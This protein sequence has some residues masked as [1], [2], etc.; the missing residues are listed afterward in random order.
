[1][2]VGTIVGLLILLSIIPIASA[3]CVECPDLYSGWIFF[4]PKVHADLLR[5]VTIEPVEGYLPL[6]VTVTGEVFNS[7]NKSINCIIWIKDNG[8]VL[9]FE[10]TILWWLDTCDHIAPNESIPFSF[11]FTLV[12]EGI[13]NVT[14]MVGAGDLLYH[15][16]YDTYNATIKVLGTWILYD[17]NN[18]DKI[19]DEELMNAIVDWLDNKISDIQLINVIIKWLK[20]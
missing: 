2:K 20:S 5:N 7:L 8:N 13:H 4:E 18:N 11:D 3:I 14:V 10:E 1:M 9:A 6:K 15:D 19:E 16:I 17:S 12:D